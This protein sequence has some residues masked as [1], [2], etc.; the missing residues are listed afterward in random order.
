MINS[1]FRSFP[2]I[3]PVSLRAAKAFARIMSRLLEEVAT[4]CDAQHNLDELIGGNSRDL[5]HTVQRR[6]ATLLSTM[7]RINTREYIAWN[8]LWD[9]RVCRELGFSHEY[10]TFELAVWQTAIRE[11]LEHPEQKAEILAFYGWLVLC[12]EQVVVQAFAIEELSFSV[13]RN[14]EGLQMVFLAL[15]LEGDFMGC[16]TLASRAIDTIDDLKLFYLKVIWPVLYQ[17]GELWE[18]DR[19]SVAEEHLTT[20]LIKRIMP[21]LCSRL[22]QAIAT[23]GKVVI[24]SAANEY[25]DVGARMVADFLEMDGWDVIFLG[26]NIPGWTLLDLIRRE[27]PFLVALSVASELTINKARNTIEEI[28][29]DPDIKGTKI[30]VGGYV[31]SHAPQL[32]QRVGADGFALDAESAT[33]LA[34][35]WWEA[36]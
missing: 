3:P 19:I 22:N 25:H 28:R 13:R 4:R 2:E 18:A 14:V 30:M 31:F 8:M 36:R 24:S 15:L 11:Q 21:V 7:L 1:I 32:W 12:R 23:R 5:L 20:D 16:L 29:T 9:Y 26:A 34:D 33:R 6:H 17:I 10:F 27:Q 35:E